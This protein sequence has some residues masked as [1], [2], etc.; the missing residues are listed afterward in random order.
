M[1]NEN[2]KTLPILSY[3]ELTDE[4]VNPVLSTFPGYETS[5][6]SPLFSINDAKDV[7]AY[8]INDSTVAQNLKYVDSPE[9]SGYMA[10]KI[11]E[12]TQHDYVKYSYLKEIQ[13]T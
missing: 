4:S 9:Q 2:K 1:F 3:N 7:T 11:R 13:F 8:L 12:G 5:H 10:T 6:E